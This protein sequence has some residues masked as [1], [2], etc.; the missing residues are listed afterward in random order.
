MTS[1]GLTGIPEQSRVPVDDGIGAK[2]PWPRVPFPQW[3]PTR[4]TFPFI[5]LRWLEAIA[6]V[7]LFHPQEGLCADI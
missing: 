1:V 6:V 5:I 4:P 2:K 7:T 3:N